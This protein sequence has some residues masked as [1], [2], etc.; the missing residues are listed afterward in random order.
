MNFIFIETK[1]KSETALKYDFSKLLKYKFEVYG[2]QEYLNDFYNDSLDTKDII[3]KIKKS[4]EA[5]IG[6][7]FKIQY[8]CIEQILEIIEC[9]NK[10]ETY[11]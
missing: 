2:I 1:M 6:I 5:E 11:I 4:D 7:C 3:E 10:F 8:D 9:L